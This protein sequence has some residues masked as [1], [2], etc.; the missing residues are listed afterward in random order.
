MEGNLLPKKS[1]GSRGLPPTQSERPLSAQPRRP[2]G[3]RGAGAEG[4]LLQGRPSRSRGGCQ[5]S[6]AESRGK[7]VSEARGHCHWLQNS[8]L[9]GAG[10]EGSRER[11]GA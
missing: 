3:C 4:L 10:Q 1:P 9:P 8:P 6:A 5:V 7:H 11:Q 2:A